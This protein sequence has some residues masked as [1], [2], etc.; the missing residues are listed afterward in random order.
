MIL[1]KVLIIDFVFTFEIA[2][3]Q[4]KSRERE[5]EGDPAAYTWKLD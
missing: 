3:K 1:E 4:L 2:I 5:I